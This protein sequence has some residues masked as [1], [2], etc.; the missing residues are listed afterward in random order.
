MSIIKMPER[1]NPKRLYLPL[2]AMA[3]FVLFYVIA[4]LNYPGGSWNDPQHNGFSFWNNYLCD[5]L[6]T[7]AINGALN[8]ARIWSRTAL[9]ILCAGLF[10]LWYHLPILFAVKTLGVKIMWWGG[11]LA[12]VS[13]LSLSDKTHDTSVWISGF[14]GTV[15]LVALVVELV[16]NK[17]TTL[18][19]LGIVCIVVF[20]VNYG[21]YETGF[22]IRILPIFQ[23][24]T[25]TLFF[26]WFI[27]ISRVLFRVNRQIYPFKTKGK[28]HEFS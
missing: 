1:V 21:I 23:K 16:R 4:A 10:Y 5:L 22:G 2:A 14:L 12:F 26:L 28:R 20:L 6:D 13:T 9:A 18:Y 3:L 11:M 15:A 25:F 7:Y 17:Y 24:L 27:Q 8:E 19:P